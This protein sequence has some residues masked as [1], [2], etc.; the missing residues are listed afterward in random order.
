MSLQLR[1]TVGASQ[2]TSGVMSPYVPP[3][4]D[5][6]A[7]RYPARYTV[8]TTT[9]YNSDTGRYDLTELKQAWLAYATHAPSVWVTLPDAGSVA[10]NETAIRNAINA[11]V[12]ASGTA[13]VDNLRGIRLTTGGD[14]G[15]A[16]SLESVV[17]FDNNGIARWMYIQGAAVGSTLRGEG[18]RVGL[19]DAALMPKF[20]LTTY[21]TTALE[22][23]ESTRRV[24]ITG[25][26]FRTAPSALAGLRAGIYG[27]PG[28]GAA[29]TFTFKGF[30][31]FDTT[32]FPPDFPTSPAYRA[33]DTPTD[34]ILDRCIFE[35][36][37]EIR[38]KRV[39]LANINRFACV[40]S[41]IECAGDPGNSDSQAIQWSPIAG[42]S[43]V[44][45]CEIACA[46]GEHIL[47][48]GSGIGSTDYQPHDIVVTDNFLTFRDRWNPNNQD[49]LHK[50]HF[51]IKIGVR[52]LF[53]A[54]IVDKFYGFNRLA[55]QAAAV[56]IKVTDQSSNEAFVLTRD[57]TVRLNKLTRC[58]G[59][60]LL[61]AR[62]IGTGN[63]KAT[64]RIE[65]AHNM[66][67]PW[68]TTEFAHGPAVAGLQ[69]GGST[70]GSS[71][72][73][74]EYYLAT[75]ISVHHNTFW[76]ANGPGE[77]Q[78]VF[79]LY[80]GGL[81]PQVVRHEISDNVF[82]NVTPYFGWAWEGQIDGNS[83]GL[84][85]MWTGTA[86]TDTT[87]VGNVIGGVTDPAAQV[88]AALGAS[89]IGVT[90]YAGLLLNAAMEPQPGSP[91]LGAA[92]DGG[93]SGAVPSFINTVLA[94]VATGRG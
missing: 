78:N 83:V 8:P 34:I 13:N 25:C 55:G 12:A 61:S 85:T 65:F 40:D 49:R 84:P 52:V 80:Y 50:N 86:R 5:F 94:R 39:I 15:Q 26:H 60:F 42:D 67:V 6:S 59:G 45:N 90:T 18:Q 53:E 24:R 66:I 87:A 81:V 38:Y 41:W 31:G 7:A 10:A 91:I 28:T 9:E 36:D 77:F 70:S 69:L 93:D 21:N 33:P 46:W 19:D 44:R 73:D 37:D 35:G 27:F 57:V 2:V 43:I 20:G 22:L 48:G 32:V 17:L 76:G 79:A 64:K 16:N 23:G 30:I 47:V 3:T 58:S 72:G 4:G 71:G 82:G 11:A 89:N 68:D 88:V 54:N 62:D 74:A 92:S 56:V 75:D 29:N 63:F 51:E 14:Y 1:F